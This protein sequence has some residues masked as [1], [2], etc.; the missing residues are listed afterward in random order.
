MTHDEIGNNNA[1]ASLEQFEIADLDMMNRNGQSTHPLVPR[2]Q[3]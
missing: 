1:P 3:S 2:C